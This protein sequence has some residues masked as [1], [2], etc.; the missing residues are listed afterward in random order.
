MKKIWKITIG[1]LHQKIL[2]VLMGFLVALLLCGLGISIFE[3][4]FLTETVSD[5]RNEQQQSIE[6]V[7]GNTMNEVVNVSMTRTNALQAYI[8]DD[9]F[10]DI[11]G[12]V[13]TL[14]SIATG[15][16]ESADSL[17]PAPFE[18]PDVKN[19]GKLSA[20]VL[21]EE[22]VDYKNSKYLAIAAHMSRTM[23]AM[24][25]SSDYLHNCYFG[26]A[27]G[28]HLCVDDSSANK[29]DENGKLMSFPVRERPWY[30]GAAEAG[31][32]FFTGIEVDTYTDNIGIECAA[33]V[34]AN[35]ELV[36]VV[37][38]DLFL[39][40]MSDYVRSSN[41]A[42]G[43]ICIISDKGQVIFAPRDNGLFNVE[44]SDV[45]Q[46]IRKSENKQLAN[47]AAS[48]LKEKTQ[49]TEITVDSKGYY[50]IGSPIQTVGW[51]VISV[52]DK[53]TTELP[54]K[55]LLDEYLRINKEFTER[56]KSVMSNVNK[57]VLLTV[58]L[59]V[60]IAI[61]AAMILANRI[62]R[63]IESM[64]NEIVVGAN[65]GKL[66]E[67]KDI[68]RTNDEIEVLAES[69]DDLSKKTKKYIE[70]ITKITAEKERISTELAL[71]TQIQANMLPNM[72]P[73]YP[74]RDDFSLY[75]SMT[76]AKEVGGDFYNFFLIDND[77]LGMVMADVSGKG[78]PAALFMM[79]SKILIENLAI[80]G[81]EPAEVLTRANEKICKDNKSDMFVT[82]WY[83]VLEIS[84][85]KVKAS[86]AGHEYPVLKGKSGKFEIF[87]DKHGFVLGGMEGMRYRQYEF[88]MDHGDSL[89]LYT[90]GVPEANNAENEQFG[91]ERLLDALN[92]EPDAEP[93]KMLENV[94]A[95]VDGFV[96]SAEQ[97]DDLTMLGVKRT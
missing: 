82:V 73:P 39:G 38:A 97:F 46:D 62:V 41:S 26:L 27:D 16:F 8:A 72:F 92:T 68:Y 42:S 15:L 74:D 96:G 14:Q 86:S 81:M 36:G 45:A 49:L 40:E 3:V 33:P 78:I 77:H 17:K 44:A 21:C 56:F 53:D 54:T 11:K 12:D 87:K 18:L 69:F 7:S 80:G 10:E 65:T 24:C 88:E 75:A 59:I 85:G 37:G 32:L 60:L 64:T 67:M 95:G 90:D 76:P 1:G 58:A 52:V 22:G 48:S 61:Y 6:K 25:E 47:F 71:A 94:K 50:M 55:M 23:I 4:S 83:G 29:F 28:T 19:D 79:A 34:Y 89:F 31:E 57:L 93:Q 91:M 63:P 51:A 20:Q 2:T 5:T 30:T 66:F 13:M 9:M 70:H 43:F 84:T 35:G